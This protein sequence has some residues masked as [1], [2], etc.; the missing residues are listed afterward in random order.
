MGNEIE[1]CRR[2]QLQGKKDIKTYRGI[3]QKK[4]PNLESPNIDDID[5]FGTY[6]PD[7][8]K[9]QAPS[10]HPDSVYSNFPKFSNYE[11]EPVTDPIY[12]NQANQEYYQPAQIQQNISL[13][14]YENNQYINTYTTYPQENVL[15]Q[16]Q[17]LEPGI[18][19]TTTTTTTTNQYTQ[20]QIEIKSSTS[21]NYIQ[22]LPQNYA[23]TVS[24]PVNYN[25]N[26][27]S[28]D[29]VEYINSSSNQ[30]ISNQNI[31][32]TQTNNYI[33]SKP[34]SYFQSENIQDIQYVQKPKIYTESEPIQYINQAP[35]TYI[36]YDSQPK[37]QQEITFIKGQNSN[38]NNY[39]EETNLQNYNYNENYVE[40]VRKPIYIEETKKAEYI[41]YQPQT[42][43]QTQTQNN[44]QYIQEPQNK[45]V[46]SETSSTQYI[47]S[48]P[49]QESE[50]IQY[51]EPQ[52]QIEYTIP[53]VQSKQNQ[54][55]KFYIESQ[56]QINAN[57]QPKNSQN[58]IKKKYV[59]KPL[60]KQEKKEK[61]K[62]E[63]K[64]QLP[65]SQSEEEFPDD[66][67]KG[68]E[69]LD[70]SEAEPQP[71]KNIDMD[72]E[73]EEKREKNKYNKYNN[74]KNKKQMKYIDSE[75][76]SKVDDIYDEIK[77]KK[78]YRNNN[79]YNNKE[80]RDFSPYGNKM[81]YPE[82]DPSFKRPK[83]KKGYKVYDE[84]DNG[85]NKA[86]YEGGMLNGRK[87]GIGKLTESR[88]NREIL[89][90]RF[91]NGKVRGKGIMRDS[92]GSS[93]I[94]DFEDSKREELEFK[95][96]KFNGRGRVNIK[97]DE[98]EIEGI[99]RNGEIEKENANVFCGGKS[100]NAAI[101]EKNKETAACQAPS[102]ITNIFSK[103]FD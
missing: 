23:T 92:Q 35:E 70:L 64:E 71:Y 29:P 86:F 17:Y 102:F 94:G 55:Q 21:N 9:E 54:K 60:I 12:S 50:Q 99:F 67:Q 36:N 72:N 95:N 84:E 61:D 81:F 97:E 8:N 27:T 33:E 3:Q 90:G 91:I 66:V 103:I 28:S 57:S 42:Q 100:T 40:V 16:G 7:K 43:A 22:N 82:N 52:K 74:N 31:Q 30:Y 46:K 59:S 68:P 76:D 65:N 4:F 44:I 80:E 45:F 98:S 89:E 1:C 15:S 77:D 6:H 39:I 48:S 58:K 51:I 5:D 11:I 38:N 47:S 83:G 13:P 18:T 20:P 78:I 93:Y 19:T 37:T 2:P 10:G 101:I 69:D 25:Y 26:Y 53:R 41:E 88:P 56:Q 73:R 63:V 75:E 79:N 85:S 49:P 96:N 62:K 24:E 14:Q 32:N 87:H 34:V